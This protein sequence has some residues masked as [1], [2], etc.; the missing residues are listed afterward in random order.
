MGP[1]AFF[2][3]AWATRRL[4]LCQ[5]DPKYESDLVL[6]MRVRRPVAMRVV[7][8]VVVM[9]V[10]GVAVI[11]VVHQFLWHVREQLA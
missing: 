11:V 5:A 8:I 10:Q 9:I 1:P 7:V 6:L 2:E 4:A 3:P